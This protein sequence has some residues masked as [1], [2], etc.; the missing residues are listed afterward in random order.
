MPCSA[1][2]SAPCSRP[3]RTNRAG[4]TWSY[5]ISTP[6][7]ASRSARA[8]AARSHFRDHPGT[9]PRLSPHRQQADTS[10]ATK[11]IT[12]GPAGRSCHVR[13]GWP[14]ASALSPLTRSELTT[15]DDPLNAA[16]R[17]LPMVPVDKST[18]STVRTARP[19]LDLLDGSR[20][21][22]VYHFMFDPAWDDG[23][24]GCSC[25]V[26]NFG[27]LHPQPRRQP[28]PRHPATA[29]I[30]SRPRRRSPVLL[31]QRLQLRL[32]RHR[33]TRPSRRSSTTTRR[34]RSSKPRAA[35]RV[36]RVDQ[37]GPVGSSAT[38]PASSTPTPP[39]RRGG[40]LL[41]EHLQLPRPDRAGSPR[42]L[43]I[44]RH[45]MPVPPLEPRR[46]PSRR[47]VVCPRSTT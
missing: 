7:S 38:A 8:L 34:P 43:R 29:L 21:L 47:P 14:R 46:L 45:V 27:H 30:R 24:P 39:T 31:S 13:I 41:D 23:C 37:P 18:T 28:D 1:R 11:G 22:L 4:A 2:W 42:R 35:R 10:S 20:Q 26:D 5:G 12:D 36:D 40:D 32:P 25:C 16:R 19:L 3:C 33:S 9:R 44:L 6:S 15:P 17:R